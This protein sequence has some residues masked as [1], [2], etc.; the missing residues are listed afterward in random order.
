MYCCKNCGAY[1][2]RNRNADNVRDRRGKYTSVVGKSLAEWCNENG[3]RGQRL[4]AEYSKENKIAIEDIAAGSHKKACWIC[5]NCGYEFKTVV[6][7][8]THNITNCPAC[9]GRVAIYNNFYE[10]CMHNGERGKRIL[11]EYST[12]NELSPEEIAPHSGDRVQW[13][14]STCNRKWDT[15]LSSRTGKRQSE[16]PYCSRSKTSYGEQ[17]IYHVLK[18]ELSGHEV[19]N[20]AKVAGHEVDILIS[21]LMLGIEYSGY[22]FHHNRTERDRNKKYALDK[23]GYTIITIVEKQSDLE[24]DLDGTF[25]FVRQ[26]PFNEVEML[27]YVKTYLEDNYN[28]SI[29]I[30]L[31]GVEKELCRYNSTSNY[32]DLE[33]II[34]LR[35]MGKT[36]KQIG[37]IFDCTDRCICDKLQRVDK[38]ELFDKEQIICGIINISRFGDSAEKIA[39]DFELDI[40][41]V[42]KIQSYIKK[43]SVI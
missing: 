27:E 39:S 8:R 29:G 36:L 32:F 23:M 6:Y 26:T 7:Y 15:I 3:E 25:S 37:G 12:E 10:W 20:R 40:D 14:C 9:A 13:I 5:S 31:S 1:A 41:F 24:G 35:V 16:C 30:S 4:I 19:L 43:Y 42:K 2:S 21:D 22:K 34:F 18:R 38:D 28:I 17:I 33:E 11:A